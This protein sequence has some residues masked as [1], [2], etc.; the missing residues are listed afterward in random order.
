MW[1]VKDFYARIMGDMTKT[2]FAAGPVSWYNKIPLEIAGISRGM[3][4]G[5]N[6]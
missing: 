1:S 4:G 6:S 3:S 2:G 5:R